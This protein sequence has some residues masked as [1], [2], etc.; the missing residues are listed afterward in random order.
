MRQACIHL[1]FISNQLVFYKV[2][3][4]LGKKTE[5]QR[6]R[7]GVSEETSPE[8]ISRRTSRRKER[9]NDQAYRDWWLC[10]S[11]RNVGARNDTR[12]TSSTG[13]LD[14]QGRS[15]LRHRSDNREWQMR[16]QNRKAPRAAPSA[17]HR[18]TS[19]GGAD[20]NCAGRRCASRSCATTIV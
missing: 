11:R 4:I 10:P 6:R 2:H 15:R 8:T 16:N 20:R 13:Q 7:R 18:S 17:P 1:P 19:R 12:A 14:F 3:L 9:N 5:K